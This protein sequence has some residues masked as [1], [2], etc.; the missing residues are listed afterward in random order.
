MKHELTLTSM[1]GSVDMQSEVIDIVVESIDGSTSVNLSNVRTI[2]NMPI[3]ESCIPR[4]SD[5]NK[6]SHLCDLNI[7][8]QDDTQVGLIIG[9]KEKPML[10]IPMEYRSGRE[11]EPIAIRYSLGWSLMGPVGG[12]KSSERQEETF[13]RIGRELLHY[14]FEFSGLMNAEVPDWRVR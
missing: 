11:D 12:K 13:N 14:S 9:L 2:E 10:F 3:S 8:E 6:W 5:L 1:T 4:K 7:E